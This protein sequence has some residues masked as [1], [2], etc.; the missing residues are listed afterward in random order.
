MKARETVALGRELLGGNGILSDFLIAKV[1]IIDRF[2]FC[3]KNRIKFW[4][5]D[6]H[7]GVILQAF[8]DLEPIYTYE[9]TYDINSLVT[10]REI[11][12]LASFKPVASRQRSRM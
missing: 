8:C 7:F 2:N 10:G 5:T 1:H 12:G 3:L 4:S 6:F 9:G 11:T